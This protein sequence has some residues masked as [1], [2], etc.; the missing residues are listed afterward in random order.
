M[1]GFKGAS[2]LREGAYPPSAAWC[3]EIKPVL[4]NL[5]S[6]SQHQQSLKYRTHSPRKK[7]ISRMLATVKIMSMIESFSISWNECAHAL[8]RPASTST[9]HGS[10]QLHLCF[11][12]SSVSWEST[13]WIYKL[14]PLY[15]FLFDFSLTCPCSGKENKYNQACCVRSI[16]CCNKTLPWR[17]ALSFL[18]HDCSENSPRWRAMGWRFWA[19]SRSLYWLLACILAKRFV[20]TNAYSS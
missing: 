13:S 5:L 18:S 6:R 4:T 9:A 19:P 14:F 15:F 3:G 8:G 11:G 17:K 2:V 16:A 10:L 20:R 12:S 7:S 1:K